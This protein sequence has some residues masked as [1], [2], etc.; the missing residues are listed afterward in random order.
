M[1]K[2][3]ILNPTI[4]TNGNQGVIIVNDYEKECTSRFEG[5]YTQEEVDL[6]NRLYEECS[7]EILNIKAIE[8]LLKQGADPLGA[9]STSGW[10]LLY[11]IYGEILRD[12]QDSKSI[13]IPTITKMFLKSGMD[14][15]NP[16]VPYDDSDSINPMWMFAFV[17]NENSIYALEMLLDN[18][19]SADSVGEMWGHATCDILNISCGDPCND[20]FWNHECTWLM[21][22]MMLCA[23]YD[24]VLNNDEYLRRFIDYSHNNYDLHKFRKWND[25]YY[26]FDTSRCKGKP[27]LR[28]SVVKI[29]EAKSNKEVWEIDI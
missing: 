14:I 29:Y 7:K 10:G 20:E 26:V 9:T 27:E 23:S 19:L 8:E 13:N 16:R 17:M 3:L 5:T 18:G 21:K 22:M 6:N 11:H 4:V 12:S 2:S 1:R 15:D 25:F 28:G 24:H